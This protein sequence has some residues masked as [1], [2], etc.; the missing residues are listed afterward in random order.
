M[1]VGRE[2]GDCR[3]MVNE[4]S[5]LGVPTRGGVVVPFSELG[6]TQGRKGAGRISLLSTG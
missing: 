5:V 6:N 2:A 4:F 1:R 3:V